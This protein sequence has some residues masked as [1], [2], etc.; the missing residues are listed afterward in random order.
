LTQDHINSLIQLIRENWSDS[1]AW[2]DFVK[3]MRLVFMQEQEA[4]G[5]SRDSDRWALLPGF[6]CQAAG[7]DPDSTK[8]L[9][10]AWLM[11]YSAAHIVD[12]VEDGDLSS[13]VSELGGPASAINVANGLFLS[14]SLILNKLHERDY[15]TDLA[16][17]INADF[18]NTILVM[19]SGQHRDL[20]NRQMTLKQWWEIAE[21]KSSSFFSLAC[22]CGAR[23][24]IEDAEK[25]KGYSDYGYHL[26]LMLQIHDDI[27]DLQSIYIPG[28][29]K[30][31]DNIHKSLAV[32][33]A[34]DVLP[35]TEKLQLEQ[36]MRTTPREPGVGNRVVELLDKSGAGLYLLAELQR[37]Q[38]LGIAA[39]QK[40][41]PSSPAGEKLAA[42]MHE[43]NINNFTQG[44][45][46]EI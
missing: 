41:N 12:S 23:L 36:W 9:S 14:A 7:G 4:A 27:E 40:A 28:E 21:A 38:D 39:L 11:L 20:L 42:F 30:L 15:P 16:S 22:R 46:N 3:A 2:P 5:S 25:I 29:V 26:G 32:V 10:A 35:P 8:E 24:G 1:R 43:L 18:Y 34:L 13:E 6:C 19:T 45:I 44:N 17:K 33:Y 31:P 37:H